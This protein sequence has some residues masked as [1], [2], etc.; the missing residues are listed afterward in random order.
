MIGKPY[1]IIGDIINRFPESKNGERVSK[2]SKDDE[3]E[4][5]SHVN[6]FN[7]NVLSLPI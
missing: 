4:N 3:N 1:F 2:N 7:V 5:K 6:V